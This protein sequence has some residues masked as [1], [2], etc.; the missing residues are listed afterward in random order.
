MP[1]PQQP[2]F[3]AQTAHHPFDGG[4]VTLLGAVS[5][6]TGAMTQVEIG[7]KK[8]LVDCGIAQ[9][10]EARRW[11]MPAAA[12][13]SDAVVLTHGHADH[14]GSLPLLLDAGYG[15]PI[16]GTPSTLELAAL[17]MEDGLRLQGASAEQ[18][19]AFLRRFRKLWKP[20]GYAASADGPA[21]ALPDS[22]ARF[23]FTKPGNTRVK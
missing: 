21:V 1:S 4:A 9:G 17:G 11:R 7:G 23:A 10:D 13:A 22:D 2:S 16:F 20:A 8:I 5:A 3:F 15:G 14:I 6:V 12:T 18:I 19:A